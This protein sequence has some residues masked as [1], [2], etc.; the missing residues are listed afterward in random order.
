MVGKAEE[1]L[2][3]KNY[4]L[5]RVVLRQI[6]CVDKSA[7]LCGG[8]L[9]LDSR[10]ISS[11][12]ENHNIYFQKLIIISSLKFVGDFKRELYLQHERYAFKLRSIRLKNVERY[13][14]VKASFLISNHLNP[15]FL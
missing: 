9:Q 6:L 5:K 13:N 10:F 7:Y 15:Q 4:A 8:C 11:L 2:S 14:S 3:I 12:V 1:K